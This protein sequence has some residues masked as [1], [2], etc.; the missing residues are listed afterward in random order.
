MTARVFVVQQ[1]SVFDRQKGHFVPKYDLSPATKY[2]RLVFLIGPGNIYR[3]RLQQA[4]KQIQEVMH[5]YSAA[6]YILA[7]GDPVAIALA[8][9]A[10][11]QKTGGVVNLLK[12]DRLNTSYN[13]FNIGNR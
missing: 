2:G 1:P 13:E 5:D 10:A 12:W 7:V 11:S 8:V 6:D 3:D 4:Q 9:I